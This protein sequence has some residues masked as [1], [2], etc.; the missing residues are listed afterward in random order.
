[1]LTAVPDTPHLADGETEAQG[2][3]APEAVIHP[4]PAACAPSPSHPHA[5]A[6]APDPRGR[7]RG[8]A[9]WGGAS[10]LLCCLFRETLGLGAAASAAQR[11]ER[12]PCRPAPPPPSPRPVPTIAPPPPSPSPRPASR[13]ATNFGQS[14]GSGGGGALRAGGESA[15]RNAQDALFPEPPNVLGPGRG[16]PDITA[17][18]APPRAARDLGL[19]FPSGDPRRPQGGGCYPRQ[20]AAAAPARK[21]LAARVRGVGGR[22][23]KEGQ[24]VE[25]EGSG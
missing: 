22:R 3:A 12:R 24:W 23:R 10:V 8:R 14:G 2:Q 4:Q 19:V 7:L 13:L 5:V 16:G 17:R 25:P 1:M 20:G 15:R 6:P 21:V 18:A 11:S 9:G